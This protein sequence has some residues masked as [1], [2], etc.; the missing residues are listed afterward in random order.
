[1][2]SD[3]VFYSVNLTHSA[4]VEDEMK[5]FV[6][7]MV[8]SVFLTAMSFALLKPNTRRMHQIE[9]NNHYVEKTGE[10]TPTRRKSLT[11]FITQLCIEYTS[12]KQAGFEL[13][14]GVVMA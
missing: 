9:L 13:A 2:S 5:M 6:L 12:P 10:K 1:M 7:E 14:T 4:D 3:F 8:F 11:N